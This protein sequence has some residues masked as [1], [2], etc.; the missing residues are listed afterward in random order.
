[1]RA[2]RHPTRR[3]LLG[4]VWVAVAVAA[5]AAPGGPPRAEP[6]LQLVYVTAQ[7]CGF[8]AAFE[9]GRFEEMRDLAAARDVAVRV[10]R[11]ARFQSYAEDPFPEDLD[12]L[13]RAGVRSGTP[14]FLLVR[15]GR[16]VASA[17]GTAGYEET[18]KPVLLDPAGPT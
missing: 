13:K 9:A 17:F 12:W 2:P 4:L 6:G 16:I 7:N 15:D 3:R 14:R 5:V 11:V 18:I 8:C 10:V 1:M